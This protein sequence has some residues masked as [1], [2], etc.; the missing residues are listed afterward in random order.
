MPDIIPLPVP[1]S[2]I[3]KF[4]AKVKF[5]G[6]EDCWTWKGG[7][8]PRG[9]GYLSHKR[10]L[11]AHR[12]SY[13]IVHG[14]LPEGLQICHECDNPSCVNPSHLFAGTAQENSHDCVRKGR[15]VSAM[16]KFTKEQV[17]A[18]RADNRNYRDI[19]K[20]YGVH[21]KTISYMKRGLSYKHVPMPA[22]LTGGAEG[23]G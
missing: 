13:A 4:M 18:I 16:T 22:T 14:D 6:S 20:E 23:E 9:Y 11:R 10:N 12:V 2:I 8:S 1:Q 19:A 21:D 17:I 15:H 7:K 3:H 5:S